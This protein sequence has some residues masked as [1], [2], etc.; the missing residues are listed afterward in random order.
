VA[1]DADDPAAV[2]VNP[3]AFRGSHYA[4]MP[5]RLA[6]I[7]VRCSTS[8]AGVCSQCGAPYER[9]VERGELKPLPTSG[10]YTSRTDSYADGPM[11]RGGNHQRRAGSQMC[12]RERIHL[13][14]RPTCS[15]PPGPTRPAVVLDPFV[16]SGTTLVAANALERDALGLD[17]SA[18]YLRMAARRLD[19]PHAR[20]LAEPADDGPGPLFPGGTP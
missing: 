11:D 10:T 3:E 18:D 20:P 5:R 2:L 6:E 19:R 16:G 9:V 17:A 14:W 8:E 13:G 4:V 12:Y 1:S 7:L 15:C